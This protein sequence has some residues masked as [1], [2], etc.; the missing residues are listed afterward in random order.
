MLEWKK[1]KFNF[2]FFSDDVKAEC[3]AM[4]SGDSDKMS[5]G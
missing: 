5:I 4:S 3:S 2:N 1:I